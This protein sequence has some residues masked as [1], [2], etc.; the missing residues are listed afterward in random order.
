MI[1]WFSIDCLLSVFLIYHCS[2]SGDVTVV[3]YLALTILG[4]NTINGRS[5]V[6]DE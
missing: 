1:Y 3:G 6:N 4:H 2:G 5:C